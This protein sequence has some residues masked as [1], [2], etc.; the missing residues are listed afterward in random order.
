MRPSVV[1]CG[2]YHK[3]PERLRRLFCELETAGCRIL[4]PISLDFGS[5]DTFVTTPTESELSPSDIERFHLRAIRDASFIF[6]HA[7]DGYIGLST[8]YELGYASALGKPAFTHT[9]LVDEM[10]RT[11]THI[12][13]SVFEALEQFKLA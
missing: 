2:S 11:R 12:V 10:L 4:S 13:Q 7:P 6:V 5:N 3:A 9:Q 8:A 1:L